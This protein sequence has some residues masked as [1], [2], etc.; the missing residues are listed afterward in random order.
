M[1][2]SNVQQDYKF[3]PGHRHSGTMIIKQEEKQDQ[4]KAF[5]PFK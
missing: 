5:Q 3:L 4:N 2:K 1:K